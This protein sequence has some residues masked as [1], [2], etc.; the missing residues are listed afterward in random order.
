MGRVGRRKTVRILILVAAA[1]LN[2]IYHYADCV[3]VQ[4]HHVV[5][6]V[7]SSRHLVFVVYEP[8]QDA[9][10]HHLEELQVA[11]SKTIPPHASDLFHWTA[12]LHDAWIDDSPHLQPVAHPR[13]GSM[14]PSPNVGVPVTI[15]DNV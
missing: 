10:V 12:P 4:V 14:T 2:I 3:S 6:C 13:R 8:A 11:D 7:Q 5:V 9:Q 15:L 1:E